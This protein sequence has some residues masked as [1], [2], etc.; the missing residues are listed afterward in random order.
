MAANPSPSTPRPPYVGRV[1]QRRKP[2]QRGR[3][4]PRAHTGS[5]PP[6]T[7]RHALTGAASWREA[8]AEAGVRGPARAVRPASAR[9]G[10]S[11]SCVGAPRF[12]SPHP[13]AALRVPPAH[14]PPAVERRQ[15]GGGGGRGSETDSEQ[16]QGVGGAVA[17]P[18]VG[19]VS[20]DALG[21][22]VSRAALLG[23]RPTPIEICSRARGRARSPPAFPR[24]GLLRMLGPCANTRPGASRRLAGGRGAAAA[25]AAEGAA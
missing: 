2:I 18:S 10:R 7:G 14:S 3:S 15:R 11:P 6:A 5:V 24:C 9:N 19:C 16:T 17:S 1:A 21:G 8:R 23:T 13:T 4:L 20:G 12:G 25:T 22:C